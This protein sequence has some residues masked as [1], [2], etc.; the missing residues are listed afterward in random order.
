MITDA[1]AANADSALHF[2]LPHQE[3]A[4]SKEAPVRLTWDDLEYFWV[5]HQIGIA[6]IE[7]V[8]GYENF[9]VTDELNIEF[10]ELVRDEHS[11][12]MADEEAKDQP[13]PESPYGDEQSA[14]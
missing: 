1:L 9:E 13:A 8:P 14:G 6:D 7:K 2:G 5:H 10:E 11:A 4:A 3:A 12:I